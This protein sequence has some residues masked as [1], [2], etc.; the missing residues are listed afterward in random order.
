MADGPPRNW[1]AM[2]MSSGWYGSTAYFAVLALG[3]A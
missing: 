1:F 3:D 2:A